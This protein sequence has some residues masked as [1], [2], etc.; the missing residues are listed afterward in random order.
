M[1]CLSAFNYAPVWQRAI[2]AIEFNDGKNRGGG[3]WVDLGQ[4]FTADLIDALS[5]QAKFLERCAQGGPD[6]FC[7]S[8]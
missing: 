7:A 2:S 1:I 5:G 8:P 6:R 4:S 3:G